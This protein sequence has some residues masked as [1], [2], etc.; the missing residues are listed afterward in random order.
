MDSAMETWHLC[1]E[2][3]LLCWKLG[4]RLMLWP[5]ALF[6]CLCVYKIQLWLV[7]RLDAVHRLYL[8]RHKR[9]HEYYS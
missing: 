2:V 9:P 5:S 7:C 3:R 6:M 8:S 1:F 4:L